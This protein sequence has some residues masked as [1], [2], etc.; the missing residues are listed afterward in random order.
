MSDLDDLMVRIDEINA[1]AAVDLSST[2]IDDLITYHRRARAR[3]AS[4]EKIGEQP[5]VNLVELLKL[6]KTEPVKITRR[7]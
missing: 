1:K 5:K 7:L 2:D 6:K 3:K 4:G